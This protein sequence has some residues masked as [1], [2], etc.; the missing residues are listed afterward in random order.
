VFGLVEAIGPAL[1][2]AVALVVAV[3][4][5]LSLVDRHALGAASGF[6]Q[7]AVVHERVARRRR[8]RGTAEVE[9]V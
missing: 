5:H 1:V 2:K 7:R 4:R 8:R 3:V 6:L 9:R